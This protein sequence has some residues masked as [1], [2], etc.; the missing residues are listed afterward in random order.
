MTILK[1]VQRLFFGLTNSFTKLTLKLMGVKFGKHLTAFLITT[2]ESPHNITIGDNVWVSKNVALYAANGITIGNDVV[3][4]KDVSLISANHGFRDKSRKI[5]QQGM[6]TGAPPIT[7]GND[8]WVGEKAIILKA[9]N[10]GD[11]AVIGAGAVV[12]KDVPAYAVVAGNPA[13]I[14]AYRQ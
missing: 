10:I 12:T 2:I 7:I 3:I 4:A 11:G 1:L 8:V 5:N 9:V 14:I 13:K 6:E